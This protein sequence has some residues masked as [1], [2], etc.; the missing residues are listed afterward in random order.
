MKG[1][2]RAQVMLLHLRSRRC[3]ITP[4]GWLAPHL[5]ARVVLRH[6]ESQQNWGMRVK[7]VAF[8]VNR[9]STEHLLKHWREQGSVMPCATS[10]CGG[11][12]LPETAAGQ[13]KQ[14]GI[15]L[16]LKGGPA[17]ELRDISVKVSGNKRGERG[18][19]SKAGHL[20]KKPGILCSRTGMVSRPAINSD[21]TSMH[22][23][24]AD[25]GHQKSMGIIPCTSHDCKRSSNWKKRGDSH[26]RRIAS[27]G[28][29]SSILPPVGG[30][31]R[32]PS[33][34]QAGLT[35]SILGNVLCSCHCRGFGE[36]VNMTG[37]VH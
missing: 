10:A 30:D 18:L 22:R 12:L 5:L 4:A 32:T 19:R 6:C 20:L 9:S 27:Q 2:A 26:T 25:V 15:A 28:R 21:D 34:R 7:Q 23:A 14:L 29:A 11:Q 37:E 3:I 13:I 36:D 16:A 1:V 24:N 8:G 31:R 17:R 35:K 33:H